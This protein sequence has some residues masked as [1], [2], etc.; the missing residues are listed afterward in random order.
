[1]RN[2][3]AAG[4]AALLLTAVSAI[5]GSPASQAEVGDDVRLNEIQVVGSHN[6]YKVLPSQAEQDL[7]RSVIFGGAD[8]MQYQHVP[9]GDQFESQGVRQIELDVWVDT[10]GGRYS[11]P[12]L[13]TLTSQG[14]Y[15]PELMNQPGVKTFHIQDVD[16]GSTCPTFVL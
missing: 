16:Y 9:L 6:S 13:R 14:P 15:H 1:K 5:T 2:R 12:L 11:Q 4:V 7:I 8:L 10:A 3:I